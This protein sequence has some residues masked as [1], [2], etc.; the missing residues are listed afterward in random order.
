MILVSACLCGENCKYSGG[1]NENEKVKE[2]VKDEEV[3]YIC[4][5]QMGGLSTPR[6]PAEIIGTAKGVID[7]TN[8]II[9]NDGTDVSSEFLNGAKK[10][11]QVAIDNKVKLAILKAKSPSCGKG[12][13]YDGTFSGNKVVGNGLTAQILIDNGIEVLT[14]EEL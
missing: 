2:F 14:E 13:V 8:K 3:I 1:N 11:L 5:E 7:G 10:S 6:N 12:I 9:T 4:P